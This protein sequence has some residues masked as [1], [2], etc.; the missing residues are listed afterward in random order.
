M[1]GWARKGGF[2]LLAGESWEWEAQQEGGKCRQRRAGMF[3]GGIPWLSVGWGN[4]GMNPGLLSRLREFW[5]R[6]MQQDQGQ[7]I[8]GVLGNAM[9]SWTGNSWSSAFFNHFLQDIS[10]PLSP[11]GRKSQSRI[12]NPWNSAL[13]FSAFH[14]CSLHSLLRPVA[15]PLKKKPLEKPPEFPRNPVCIPL[16]QREFFF[17]P[18]LNEFS[19]SRLLFQEFQKIWDGFFFPALRPGLA[20]CRITLRIYE[21]PFCG[22]RLKIPTPLPGLAVM[23]GAGRARRGPLNFPILFCFLF[24]FYFAFSPHFIPHWSLGS[25]PFLSENL[26]GL[27]SQERAVEQPGSLQERFPG[28]GTFPMF[29]SNCSEIPRPGIPGCLGGKGKSHPGTLP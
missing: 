23:C 27:L 29:L 4:L 14:T 20:L 9:G 28:S 22:R 25:S 8:P 11:P 3:W 19:S 15:K 6:G 5:E 1:P 24:P 18:L 12:P 16:L 26:S 2:V 13:E 21:L 17:F 7:G 10:I